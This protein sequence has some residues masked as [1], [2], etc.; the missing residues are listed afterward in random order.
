MYIY[1]YVCIYM[2]KDLCA[3]MDKDLCI[4]EIDGMVYIG[5]RFEEVYI[6]M[7]IYIYMYIYMCVYMC[8]YG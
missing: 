6:C 7:Y 2:D 3:Y 5:D 4:Y 8:I 1:I